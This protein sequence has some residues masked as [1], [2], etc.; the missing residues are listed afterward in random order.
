MSKEIDKCRAE[1]G[2]PPLIKK[3]RMCLKCQTMFNSHSAANRICSTC[4]SVQEGED[5]VYAFDPVI[6]F[7][8]DLTVQQMMEDIRN[9]GVSVEDY[10]D[11][12][13]YE[14]SD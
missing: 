11:R 12:G 2:L 3:K 5:T 13:F 10:I 6:E 8:Y 9:K 14:E 4:K 1:N 7:Q